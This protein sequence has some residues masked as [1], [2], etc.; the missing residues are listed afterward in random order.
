MQLAEAMFSRTRAAV[1][2]ALVMAPEA[3]LHGRE[4]ARRCGLDSAGVLSELDLL[5][6]LGVLASRR[7]GR[8]RLF[9]LDP[10]CPIAPELRSI[11][12]KTAGLRDVLAGALEPLAPLIELAYVYGSMA[13]GQPRPHSDVDVMV[14]GRAGSMQL[15]EALEPLQQVLGREVNA[16]VYKPA[17]YWKKIALGRGFPYTAHSGPKIMLLGEI[18]AT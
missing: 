3:E 12:R 8:L 16:S 13:S 7:L 17:E 14:V 4:L 6:Q 2:A 18:D 9:R 10:R 15:A 1:L 5:E 11:M